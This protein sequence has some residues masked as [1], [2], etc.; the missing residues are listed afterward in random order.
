MK[1]KNFLKRV[2]LQTILFLAIAISCN[3]FAWFVYNTKVSNTITT[4]VKAWRVAF[5]NK[6]SDAIQY[7]EFNIENIYPGMDE[8]TNYITVTNEGETEA[9]ITYEL[10]EIRILKKLYTNAEYSQEELINMIKNDF[11]FKVELSVSTDILN[12]HNGN[13]TFNV[14]VIW[15]FESGNDELDTLWGNNS[16]EF[17]QTYPDK[18]GINIKL[19]LTVS[20]IN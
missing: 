11:P 18:S 1:K 3:S 6:D 17:K 20:Q 7:M 13:G 2:R 16:Y 12:A 9:E 14:K 15:P 19:K 8:Y 10:E 5:E 4:S